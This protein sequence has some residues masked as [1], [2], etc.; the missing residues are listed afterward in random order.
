[1]KN[2]AELL[3]QIRGLARSV[4]AFVFVYQ[5]LVQNILINTLSQGSLVSIPR[6]S[7]RNQLGGMAYSVFRSQKT[8]VDRHQ[9]YAVVTLDQNSIFRC[10]D[11]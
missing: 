2:T 1:M 11:G 4:V 8:A 10:A 3:Y 5:G 9:L 6:R 7:Y